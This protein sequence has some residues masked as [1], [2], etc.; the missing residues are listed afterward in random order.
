MNMTFHH[1]KLFMAMDPNR[2]KG[3]VRNSSP[4]MLSSGIF[5]V[6]WCQNDQTWVECYSSS[7][8]FSYT[9]VDQYTYRVLYLSCTIYLW[10]TLR[11]PALPMQQLCCVI[12][13]S[14][15]EMLFCIVPLSWSVKYE[16]LSKTCHR[17]S[18][19]FRVLASYLARILKVSCAE[20]CVFLNLCVL[21]H[22]TFRGNHSELKTM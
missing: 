1:P 12:E 13:S 17:V 8:Y 11:V 7:V 3:N 4:F 22:M 14:W 10:C 21:H 2:R 9:Y 18:F 20:S 16:F 5:Y 15:I 19:F 6:C